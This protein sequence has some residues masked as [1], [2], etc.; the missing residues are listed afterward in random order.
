MGR[1]GAYLDSTTNIEHSTVFFL[2]FLYDAGVRGQ[3]RSCREQ[4]E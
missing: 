1:T 2:S 4:G 3:L